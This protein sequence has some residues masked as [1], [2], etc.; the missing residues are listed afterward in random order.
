[1]KRTLIVT[2]VLFL[3]LFSCAIFSSARADKTNLIANGDFEQLTD[4]VPTGWIILE[5]TNGSEAT[6][7]LIKGRGNIGHVDIPEGAKKGAYIAQWVNLEPNQ[8]YRLSMQAMMT[9]GKLTFAVGNTGLNVRVFGESRDEL[10]MSP[11]FWDES[12]QNSFPFVPGQWREASFN[13]NSKDVTRV[14]VSLGGFFAAG[15][16]SF[17][18]VTLVKLPSSK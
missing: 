10:P 16:Y 15:S 2:K 9:E 12:W 7:P 6:F 13:F 3:F 4:N 5:G 8:N 1:M 11:L 17:D 18:D 14:L